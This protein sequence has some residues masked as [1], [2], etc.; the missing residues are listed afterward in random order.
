MW[1]GLILVAANLVMK[2]SSIRAIIFS[3]ASIVGGGSPGG[4]A[5]S[6]P[7]GGITVNPPGQGVTVPF[8]GFPLPVPFLSTQQTSPTNTLV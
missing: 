5:S 3:G 1:I 7:S 4:S 6:D 2:W 8:G